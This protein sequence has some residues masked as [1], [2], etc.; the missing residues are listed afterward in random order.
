MESLLEPFEPPPEKKPL[1]VGPMCFGLAAA[2]AVIWLG[3]LAWRISMGP[4]DADLRRL[5]LRAD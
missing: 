4:A 2:A 3:V 5:V 1:P